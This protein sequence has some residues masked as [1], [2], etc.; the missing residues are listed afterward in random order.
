MNICYDT[1]ELSVDQKKDYCRKAKEICYEWWVD[2]LDCRE[3]FFRQKVEMTFEEIIEMLD[4]S[5]HFTIIWRHRVDQENFLE[6][7][8]CT[9]AKEPEY[10]LW[11]KVDKK[12]IPEFTQDLS[13]IP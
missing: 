10:F 6:V 13:L 1:R 3:S 9:I 12:H 5:S 11:I 4:N 2:K 8:F 7:G